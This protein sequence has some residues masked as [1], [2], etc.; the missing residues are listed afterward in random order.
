M[1]RIDTIAERRTSADIVFETLH[2]QIVSLE[3]MP[4]TKM[5]EVEI[6]GRFGLSRQP[7][8]EAF[9]RLSNMGLLQIRPQR[10]TIV[11]HFSLQ[12]IQNG[13]FIRKAVEVE[14]LRQACRDRDTAFDDAL[15]DSL[16]QQ[17][18]ATQGNDAETFHQL[19]YE[20]HRLLCL[21]ARTEFAF[22]TIAAQKAKVDR[23][24][25][26]SLTSQAAMQMLFDDHVEILDGVFAGQVQGVDEAIRRH[27]DRLS[28]TIEQIYETH[29]DYFGD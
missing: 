19:D 29:R 27:L 3:I 28:P 6:A 18:K 24:C 13:R 15:R 11:R 23:L 16:E 2:D 21:A 10:S 20:F 14:V 8:R 4:G 26:L 1:T 5:S 17:K 7:I 25:V 22:E 12:D 9:S